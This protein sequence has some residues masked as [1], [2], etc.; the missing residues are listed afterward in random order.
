MKISL[1]KIGIT[2][3]KNCMM[4]PKKSITAIVGLG[5]KGLFKK[6][7]SQCGICDKKD[8]SYRRAP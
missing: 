7:R 4:I 8:C 5:P 2:L 6:S 1:S 3:N